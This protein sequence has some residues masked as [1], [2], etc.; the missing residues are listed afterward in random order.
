MRR[1]GFAL[2]ELLVALA[3]FSVIAVVAYRGIAVVTQAR[4]SLDG[5][6]DRLKS[7]Q[8]AVGIIER[9]L[10][11][12]ARRPIRGA[13]GEE[14]PA[15]AGARGSLELTC[16]GFGSAA[17]EAR[18]LL[19][20][21]GYAYD[22]GELVR[23]Q[24]PVLDRAPQT[25][26]ARRAL[27]DGVAG[28]RVRYLEQGNRWLEAWPPADRT[29]DPYALPRAVEVVLRLDDYGEIRRVVELVDA[30]PAALAGAP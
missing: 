14:L 30:P 4:A 20:R 26:A 11:Q 24:Y 5:H 18:S 10:R 15:L 1:A 9:D 22:Q 27:L 2:L 3:I 29:V 8:L 17:S 13:Y 23:L 21:V 19:D 6:A 25:Q 7:V 12:A 28:L 16:F